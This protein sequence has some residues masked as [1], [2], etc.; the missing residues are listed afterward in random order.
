M[1]HSNDNFKNLSR[2]EKKEEIKR[3]K[4]E[5]K[6]L[7]KDLRAR[8]IKKRS[9]F[10]YY[11]RALG[12]SL[13]EETAEGFLALF[14]FRATAAAKIFAASTGIYGVLGAGLAFL[15]ALLTYTYIT[16]EKGHFTINMTYDM[17]QEGFIMSQYEDFSDEKLRLYT[18]P[19]VNVNAISI[20]TINR[21]VADV[22]GSH[23]G[24]GYLAYTF[25][26]KNGG[27]MTTNYGYTMNITSK[28]MGAE[29]ASWIM[30]FEDDRQTIY[31]DMSANGDP[32]ELYGYY[33][34][35]FG[36]QAYDPD[37]QYYTEDGRVGIVTTPFIDE[38][39]VMQ[40]LVT[41]FEPGEV[42]KY[43][44]V[45]WLE[46][47]DP[48]CTNDI[49]GGHVGFN[50]QFD[51]LG[52]DIEGFFKGLYREEYLVTQQGVIVDEEDDAYTVLDDDPVF[53]SEADDEKITSE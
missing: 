30:L 14:M 43:T 3:I 45:I 37:S 6:K 51:R 50:I 15:G 8:G 32:E 10:E 31:A 44:A 46:G 42:K 28:T 41:D 12:L 23:N 26:I 35:P 48:D 2:A 17:M 21:G 29:K 5:R 16:E 7:R 4:R 49:L 40:G 39:T 38:N 33:N 22:D 1:A 20:D 25:Y 11:A 13:P 24:A 47:D 36:D 34:M 52:D 18:E 19:I 53:E 27:E 9:D